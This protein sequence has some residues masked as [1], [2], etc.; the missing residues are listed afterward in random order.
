MESPLNP[1]QPPFCTTILHQ[2][3]ASYPPPTLTPHEPTLRP[4]C[5][6]PSSPL[7]G[8]ALGRR[9]EALR[10]LQMGPPAWGPEVEGWRNHM[11]YRW[12]LY[13]WFIGDIDISYIYISIVGVITY[14]IP[15]LFAYKI[16]LNAYC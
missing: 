4:G 2:H 10:M 13:M 11:V 9:T 8:T 12:F 6:Q 3:F 16:I 15:T 1:I 7:Q 14:D 5:Q